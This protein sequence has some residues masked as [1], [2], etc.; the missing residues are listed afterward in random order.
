MEKHFL[1]RIKTSRLK[2]RR[3]TE[4]LGGWSRNLFSGG[5]Q[6][7]APEL[8]KDSYSPGR[9]KSPLMFRQAL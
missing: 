8:S 2:I 4:V 3:Y 6:N 1:M 7:R 9:P 5:S